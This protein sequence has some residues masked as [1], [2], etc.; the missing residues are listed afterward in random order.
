MECWVQFLTSL[1]KKDMDIL[2]GVQQK[3]TISLRVWN[4]LEERLR[5]LGLINPEMW[6]FREDLINLDKH[7]LRGKEEEEPDYSL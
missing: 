7:L 6:R 5:E 3:A 2:K 4:I 1:Y